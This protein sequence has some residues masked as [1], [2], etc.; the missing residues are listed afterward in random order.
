MARQISNRRLIEASPRVDIHRVYDI[1]RRLGRI[2]ASRIG[3]LVLTCWGEQKA[4]I[5]RKSQA[6]E[7]RREGFVGVDI[8]VANSQSGVNIRRC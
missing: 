8:C 7:E 2:R 5:G 6:P 3:C 1:V 4:A